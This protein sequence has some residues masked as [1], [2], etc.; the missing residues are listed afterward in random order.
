[1]KRLEAYGFKSFADKI[2]IEF[3]Q[4]ITAIVGPNGSGK[5]NITDAIRWVLGEQ[6]I[7]N[8][9]G[10]KSEDIIFAGSASRR[11]LNIAEVSLV[12]DN[13][14]TLPVDFREVVVTRRLYR[15]GESEY[16]IN[17]SR[18]RLKDIYELFA[19]TGIGHDGMSIIGQNRMEDILNSRPEERR[20]YFEEAAGITKY[21]NRKRETLRKLTDTEGNLVRV[22]DIVH[23]IENQLEP[24][25]RHAEKTRAYNELSAD[26]KRCQLTQ[27]SRRYA[28]EAAHRA[29]NEQKLQK[30]R[31]EA[32]AAKTAIQQAEARQE[33][34]GKEILDLEQAMKASAE[35]NETLRQ[36]L[37]AAHREM[38]ALEER[39]EQSGAAKERLAKR[40]EEL[41]R[42]LASSVGEIGR[43]T[44]EASDQEQAL[45]AAEAALGERK[46][47]QGE[48]GALLK[49]YKEATAKT[50]ARKE[51][52]QQE[53]AKET[54]A[55]AVLERDIENSET[56]QAER[57]E[58][59]KQ[60]KAQQMALSARQET[61]GVRQ[62][63]A[64][65]EL[66]QAV[67]AQQQ[68]RHE[69]QDAQEA[70]ARRRDALA[71]LRQKLATAREKVDFLKHMQEE[72]EGFGKGPKA[73]LR[74]R[75]P[76]HKGVNG[77]V[78]ELVEIPQDY[79][80]A[81]EVALGGN[82]QNIVT[83]DT[84]TA[85]EA[86]AY[87]K[88]RH[89]GRV[90]FLPLST[91]V[92]PYPNEHERRAEG[93]EGVIGWA[94]ELVTVDAHCRKAVDFLLA[95]IL[96]VDTLDHA[97]ALAKEFKY[98]LRI[99][100][101]TGEFLAPGGSLSGGGR[102]GRE[103]SFLNRGGEIEALHASIA[104]W[105]EQE[106]TGQQASEE[107]AQKAKEAAA[108]QQAAMERVQQASEQRA[109]LRAEDR[110]L[111]EAQEAK[112]QEVAARA[113]AAQEYEASFAANANRRVLQLRKV[114]ELQQALETACRAADEAR[115]DLEDAMQDAD[116][117][118]AVLQDQ[119][120]KRTV[121]EQEL[122]RRREHIALC[123]QEKQRGEQAL[124]ESEQE[125][126]D[127]LEGLAASL[128]RLNQL[129]QEAA[130]WQDHFDAGQEEQRS[131][132]EQRMEKMA[133]AQEADRK[134]RA[135]NR[136]L[137]KVQSEL[138]QLELT[139]A[140]AEMAIEETQQAIL[141]G[142]GLTPER[143]AEEAYDW[144]P[145]RL[146]QT[147]KELA[148]KIEALGPVNPNALE[149]YEALQKR[150]DFMQKQAGDLVEA[151]D[152]LL[153]IIAEMDEAMTQQFREAFAAIQSYFG[154][155]F[156][157][158]FGGGQAELRMLD[159]H[160]VLN[161]GIDILVTLPQKKRQ[162]LA[163]LSGGERALT[164]IA[165]LFAFLRYRPSPF[166]VL[167][168]ID[169]PLD[170][171]NVVRFGRF[172]REFAAKTQFIVVTHRKG[173]MEAVDTM[174]GVTVEDAGVSRLLSVK[175]DE[176]EG[177]LDA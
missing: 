68:A 88:R 92:V 2:S 169:A 164:V 64:N 16:F 87:L 155:I 120:L 138:H 115:L 126:R 41:T 11:P 12:F 151:K 122:M 40:R 66:Q 47:Q 118:A 31:D 157:R 135:A 77:A 163:A 158:L 82:Q 104:A 136:E 20:A 50:L 38:A 25:A 176:I 161:T 150:H 67:R 148:A 9:R 102:Q 84:D 79:V 160:D 145:A 63:Q 167:D 45:K 97:L 153:H 62:Q 5:S 100:T 55:L 73:V 26:Y 74:A 89:L 10:T 18:C 57:Q 34:I 154:E 83:E 142:F 143:A 109:E 69:Q 124:K 175:L 81:I 121:L 46:A 39:Q 22:Q 71:D 29:E 42:A 140:K 165:L 48:L 134:T 19:D 35:K 166:S 49:R 171:A 56:G 144:E 14:G 172:L 128:K 13:D 117:L 24:M 132:Y 28:K 53:L 96:V 95:R 59:L 103:A 168:E 23:E 159:E 76:W 15:S 43:L 105:Q 70:L 98:R 152:N 130:S 113:K 107:A 123:R 36:R 106:G 52:C 149:E 94:H 72:Y 101:L 90:T 58:A 146:R 110:R 86:I 44:A 141:K 3:D 54:Q 114:K 119:E 6:N 93:R 147:M 131:F 156:V 99:V 61:L 111:R 21:R 80:T 30:A 116:D 129:Q 65:E 133:V 127:L 137:G 174:Y 75:E 17:R 125:E 60:A 112:A 139:G 37:E 7:R 177:Q 51:A 78:A 162:S 85:K 173:T 33:A 27:L 32:V 170:E 91:L 4:G 1:M 108:A 8:L